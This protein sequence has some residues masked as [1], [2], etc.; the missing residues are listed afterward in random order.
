MFVKLR[1]WH[2]LAITG[3]TLCGRVIPADAP[4]SADLPGEK[5]CESC[6]RIQK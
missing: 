5:S 2:I 1:S 6:L 4:T 3:K